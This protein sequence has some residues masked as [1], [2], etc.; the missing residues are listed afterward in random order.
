MATQATPQASTGDSWIDEFAR[1]NEQVVSGQQ[2]RGAQ[3]D[4]DGLLCRR[5]RSAQGVGTVRTVLRAIALLPLANSLP[6]HVVPSCQFRLSQGRFPNL[7][8]YQVGRS[9]KAMQGLAHGEGRDWLERNSVRNTC[10][11]LKNGQLRVGA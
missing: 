6:G 11:A 3:G 10:L 2:Q 7:F 5:E 9:G 1:D 4:N 8:A